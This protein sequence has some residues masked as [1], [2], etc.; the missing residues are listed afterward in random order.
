[1]YVK[2][3]YLQGLLP[4]HFYWITLLP[5]LSWS[6][7]RKRR[8]GGALRV[9]FKDLEAA[10]RPSPE[11]RCQYKTPEMFFLLKERKTVG[12]LSAISSRNGLP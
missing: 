8:P 7:L 3:H 4:S 6:C 1:M 10:Q 9:L 2:Q 12:M 5:R 11:G